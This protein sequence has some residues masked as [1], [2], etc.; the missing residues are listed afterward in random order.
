MIDTSL[1]ASVV[2]AMAMQAAPPAASSAP[3]ILPRPSGDPLAIDMDSDPLL[4]VERD[5][6]DDTR[7]QALLAAAFERSP[8]IGEAEARVDEAVAGKAVARAAQLPSGDVS[9]TSA[10]TLARAF[11]NDPNN[12]I[13]RSRRRQRTDAVASLQQPLFDFGAGAA[14]TSAARARIT[15]ADARVDA[16]VGDVGLRAISSWY[17]VFA[18]RAL[19]GLGEAFAASQAKLG[20]AVEMRI[21]EGVSARAD[22]ARVTS[23]MASADSRLARYRR[24]LAGAE[25]RFTELFGQAP[26]ADLRRAPFPTLPKLSREAAELRATTSSSVRAAEADADATKREAKAAFADI[27]PT[28]TAGIDAGRYGVFETDNDYDIR[29]RLTLRYRLFGGGDARAEQFDARAR[30]DRARADRVREEAR[31]DAAIAWADVNAL[32]DQLAALRSSYIASRL[33]RDVVTER[34]RVARGSLFDVLDAEDSYFETAAA[35]LQAVTDLDSAR[36]V[37]LA[38]IGGLSE[39]IKATPNTGSKR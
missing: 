23:F 5:F 39:A 24:A 11:S 20:E 12:I 18:F 3:T 35:Y 4:S 9:Y 36:Y 26:P 34:F 32:E 33:S 28:V 8:A 15:A 21:A 37:L 29:A 38:R 17:D 30:S 7:F 14:R 2:A 10:R 25:A 16:V 27:L 22:R 1:I 19:V 31:R 6:D 13:E